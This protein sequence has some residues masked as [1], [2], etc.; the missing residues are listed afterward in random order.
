MQEND[1][2]SRAELKAYS[3]SPIT[4]IQPSGV[5]GWLAFLVIGL[6]ILS[7]F[8]SGARLLEQMTSAL[9]NRPSLGGSAQWLS[10]QQATWSLYWITAALSFV[11]GYRLWKYHKP[12][13]IR[14]ALLSLWLLGP[15]ADFAI[16]IT[17]YTTLEIPF[18]RAAPA[19]FWGSLIG[20]IFL[21]TAWTIYLLRS[22]R[23]KNTY[24]L[25][26]KEKSSLTQWLRVRW[27]SACIDLNG[28]WVTKPKEFRVW[29]F[30]TVLWIVIGVLFLLAF[31]PYSHGYASTMSGRDYVHFMLVLLIPPY[32]YRL[33][34]AAYKKWVD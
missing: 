22:L 7:P 9:E 25:I 4:E 33:A 34:R 10:F 2:E 14:F 21:S 1:A 19:Q 20:S 18:T 23:V 5:H 24:G 30:F 17:A 3:H 31:D 11:T 13:S 32:L 16:L 29:F 15:I 27:S 28:W 12:S 26:S 6:M 8:L